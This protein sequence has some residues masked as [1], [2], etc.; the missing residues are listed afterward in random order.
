MG[1][2]D[3]ALAIAIMENNAKEGVLDKPSLTAEATSEVESESPDPSDGAK[4]YNSCV[5]IDIYLL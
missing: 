2:Q 4:I 5:F 1:D 3:I